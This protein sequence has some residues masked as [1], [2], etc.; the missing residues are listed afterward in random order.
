MFINDIVMAGPNENGAIKDPGSLG[1]VFTDLHARDR[2]LDRVVGRTRLFLLWIPT[3]LGIESIDVAGST[4]Q[5]DED[6]AVSLAFW[7]V[8]SR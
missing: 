7:G 2:R 8:G 4:S 5:P 6:A 1:Q 3:P